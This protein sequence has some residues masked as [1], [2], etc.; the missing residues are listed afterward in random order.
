M[1]RQIEEE[2]EK[3]LPNVYQWILGTDEYKALTRWENDPSYCSE[4][5]VIWIEGASGTGKTMLLMGIIRELRGR[6]REPFEP[7]PSISNYFFQ[8]TGKKS[9]NTAT[10]A[11]RSLIWMLVD[12]QWHLLSH[13]W[14][15]YDKL[16]PGLFDADDAFYQLAEI[17]EAML[18][19]PRLLPAYFVVDALNEC[20]TEEPGLQALLRVILSSV[21]SSKKVKWLLSGS[22]ESISQGVLKKAPKR[23]LT[24][25]SEKLKP[26]IDEYIESKL[27][28]LSDREGF[29]DGVVEKLRHEIGARTGSRFQWVALAF[30]ELELVNGQDP[31]DTINQLPEGLDEAYEHTFSRICT[32]KGMRKRA[33][34]CYLPSFFR[35]DRPL[36]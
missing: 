16:G 19:D 5:Q 18:Q 8:S 35:I 31:V 2:R 24:L 15:S 33:R 6:P 28:M 25:T 4:D 12:Q 10:S 26:S 11:L 34:R 36:M 7:G 29:D 13:V 17:F 3:L 20:T 30:K 14:K 22:W 32:R 21:E 9:L 1:M 27:A 23:K